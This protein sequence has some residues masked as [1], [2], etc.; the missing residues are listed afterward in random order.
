[1]SES[2]RAAFTRSIS[3]CWLRSFA[4]AIPPWVSVA[5]HDGMSASS[6][7]SL[8]PNTAMRWPFTSCFHGAYA[9][10][11][12]APIPTTPSAVAAL[13][14]SVSARPV[15]AVVDA[16]VVGDRHDIDSGYPER[17]QRP[18][19][20]A[21]V[22]AL[23]HRAA[24]LGDRRLHVHH[25]DVRGREL[26]CDRREH[27]GRVGVELRADRT[28]EVDVTPE[29]ERDRLTVPAPRA[30]R[31]RGCLDCR[32]RF[33]ASSVT[34]G[35]SDRPVLE[36]ESERVNDTMASVARTTTSPTRT[37][38]TLRRTGGG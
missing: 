36:L 34:R 16:V 12:F 11:A 28:L 31:R 30:G 6:I 14:A 27:P 35:W 1:M 5:V 23:R 26:R 25:R 4:D 15:G 33:P 7:T 24:A 10:V 21:E 37:L 17:L 8:A 32:R 20:G 38:V 19:R 18:R 3:R 2:G 9:S 13:A 29:R 22:V